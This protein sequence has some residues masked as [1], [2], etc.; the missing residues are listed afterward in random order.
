M[1]TIKSPPSTPMVYNDRLYTTGLNAVPTVRSL[2][3]QKSSMSKDHRS[4]QRVPI[5]DCK[6]EALPRTGEMDT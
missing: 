6:P 2:M 1:T 4:P 3:S 5:H